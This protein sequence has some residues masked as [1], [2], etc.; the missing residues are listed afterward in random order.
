MVITKLMAG[1]D[2]YTKQIQS[3]LNFTSDEDVVT[4]EF[5]YLAVHHP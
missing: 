1:G 4:L 2:C 5:A 3:T